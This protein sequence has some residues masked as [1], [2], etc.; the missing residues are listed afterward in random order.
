LQTFVTTSR[1]RILRRPAGFSGPTL[2]AGGVVFAVAVASFMRGPLLPDIG[3]DLRITAAD[4]AMITTAFAL[5]RLVM[6]LPA[7]RLADRLP[8]G[9]ALAGTGV[10]VAVS[11]AL[12][13]TADSL[14]QALAGVFFLGVAS[15]LTNTTGMTLFAT[16]APP[17]RRGTAMAGFS[18]ALMTG[19]T[20]GPAL[21]GAIAGVAGWRA[22]QGAAALIGVGVFAVCLLAPAGKTSRPAEQ[23]PPTTR[24]DAPPEE[25]TPYRARSPHGG[26][27]PSDE[28]PPYRA[29]TVPP[30]GPGPGLSR[31]QAAVLA[32]VPFAVFF[33]LSALPQTLLPVIGSSEL[34]LTTATIGLALGAGGVARFAGSALAGTVSDRVSRKAALIP[35]LLGMVVGVLILIPSPTL[36]TWLLAIVL[37][38]VASSGIAVAATII[39]DRVPADTV[40]RR[41]G[42]FRFTGDFGLLAGPAITGVL[43]QHSGRS[44]AMLVTA[45]VLGASALAAGLLIVEPRG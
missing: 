31:S 43:Y 36:A 34:S 5:G 8:P 30:P 33:A 41:L 13:A 24:G 29:R 42:T 9:R 27:A 19:Q 40:G 21:G 20:I 39:A 1:A 35:S 23:P 22:A 3:R 28:A 14:G 32:A 7:G 12:L 44:A 2:L 26:G 10:G 17:E 6:D 4:L 38:S 11:A 37:L 16:S 18:M 25:A 45:G 15:A